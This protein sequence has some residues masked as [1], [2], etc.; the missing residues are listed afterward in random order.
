MVGF[1]PR[2]LAIVVFT[3]TF[4]ALCIRF[5]SFGSLIILL[6]GLSLP[7]YICA[8]LLNGVFEKIEK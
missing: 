5:F 6:L 8:I 7:V 1:F 4:W 3:V 2:T